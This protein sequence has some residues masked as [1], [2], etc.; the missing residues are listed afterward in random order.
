MASEKLEREELFHAKNYF[1]KMSLF[2][3]KMRLKSVPQKLNFLM[4]NATSISYTLSRSY[5]CPCT[6]P[7]SY[8]Q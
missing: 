3:A 5:K 1:L 4:E 7:N 8:A 6:F 2:H